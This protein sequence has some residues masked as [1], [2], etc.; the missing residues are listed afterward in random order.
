[1][2]SM[3]ASPT[4]DLFKISIT[5][6]QP[7]AIE[8]PKHNVEKKETSIQIKVHTMEDGD[9]RRGLKSMKDQQE[10]EEDIEIMIGM[11]SFLSY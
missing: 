1:M 7:I 8:T 5:A 2:S 4:V 3:N 10:R 11:Y 6:V 9:S